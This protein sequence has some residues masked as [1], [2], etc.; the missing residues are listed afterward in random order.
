MCVCVCVC[1]CVWRERESVCVCVCRERERERKRERESNSD[2][3]MIA[4]TLYALLCRHVHMML[5][6]VCANLS[7][8]KLP[9][10]TKS[11]RKSMADLDLTAAISRIVK[12]WSRYHPNLVHNGADLG[13]IW[14]DGWLPPG[15]DIV[16]YRRRDGRRIPRQYHHLV[17]SDDLQS[18][19]CTVRSVQGVHACIH[20][21]ITV[22]SAP[23]ELFVDG[24]AY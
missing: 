21:C 23:L 4:C 9:I 1:A 13:H 18:V 19:L 5:H 6:T 11:H 17:R 3:P 10:S 24:I 8:F 16:V 15:A 7:V 20:V 12:P 2:R 22:W 14:R